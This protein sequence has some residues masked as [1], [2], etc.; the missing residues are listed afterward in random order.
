M[1]TLEVNSRQLIYHVMVLVGSFIEQGLLAE[2]TSQPHELLFEWSSTVLGKEKWSHIIRELLGGA[3][4]SSVYFSICA[5]SALHQWGHQQDD[6]VK[7][8]SQLL[9]NNN[10]ACFRTVSFIFHMPGFCKKQMYMH[11]ATIGTT[12][13]VFDIITLLLCHFFLAFIFFTLLFFF[14][15]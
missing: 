11:I 12:G 13:V 7:H 14:F 5:F 1:V 6:I 2:Q 8:F 10:A 3:G 4:M 9:R 15:K